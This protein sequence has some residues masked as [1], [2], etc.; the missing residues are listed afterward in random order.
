M[1]VISFLDSYKVSHKWQYPEGTE[2]VYSN[3]TI[4]GSRL[5]V[6]KYVFFGIQYFIKKYLIEE[7]NKWFALPKE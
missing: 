1:S 3:W 2:K 7:F 4:R 5:P 6:D